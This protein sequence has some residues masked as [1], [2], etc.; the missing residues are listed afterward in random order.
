VGM[1]T[2]LREGSLQRGLEQF[3]AFCAVSLILGD[4]KFLFQ[5]RC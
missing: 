1:G 3:V 4:V 2:E 5:I